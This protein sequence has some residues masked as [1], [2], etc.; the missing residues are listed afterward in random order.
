[1]DL[2]D[3]PSPSA[4]VWDARTNQ[5]T[6]RE[7]VRVNHLRNC[8]L[9]H[10]PSANKEDGPVRGLVPTPG[11]ALP[12]QYYESQGGDFVRADITFLRQDFSVNLPESDTGPWPREQRYDFVTRLPSGNYPQRG[13]VLSALRGL[14]GKDGGASSA[15]WRELLGPIT[16]KRKGE[17]ERPGLEKIPVS[18]A[19]SPGRR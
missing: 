15:H 14:T 17:Q 2:L 19:D 13:A 9:C 10:A 11:E 16:A 7:L 8:L 6:V 5:D 3:L 4:P 12:V 1:V 18:L